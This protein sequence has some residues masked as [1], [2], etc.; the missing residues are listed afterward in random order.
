MKVHLLRKLGCGVLLI[1]LLSVEAWGI[2]PD[3][4]RSFEDRSE[5]EYL[6]LPAVA[7][8]PGV[9]V[10]AGIL[11]SFSNIESTGVD[12][13]VSIAESI[14][15]TD[16]HLRVA[17]LREIPLLIPGLTFDYLFGDIFFGNFQ[18]Y[19]PGRDSPNLTIPVTGD[20]FF[21][22][23]APSLRVWERRINL[24]YALSFSQ[25]FTTDENGNEEKFA[26]H[27]LGLEAE[28][29]FT[30][31]V[32]DPSE[33]IRL[34]YTQ[35]LEAPNSSLF[36]SDSGVEDDDDPT[37][38]SEYRLSVYFPLYEDFTLVWFYQYFQTIG[39]ETVGNGGGNTGSLLLRGYP[40][41]RWRDIYGNATALEGRY[42]IRTNT[43]IDII[44]IKGVI[45][46]W[47]LAAFYEVGQVSPEADNRL[48][49]DLHVSTGAGVRMLLEAIVLR[50]DLATSDEG[51]QTY[52][53]IDQAF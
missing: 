48:Y 31:D 5:N 41:N 12:A 52:L 13:A 19:L 15:D 45:E 38:T 16:I 2:V 20:I 22:Q 7:S 4:R 32:I 14:D 26:A 21:Q 27:N 35:D 39:L 40:Q 37:T 24:T 36:G 11:S 43:P 46:G 10:F 28:L 47:Q 29:D 53:T 6:I 18:T 23:L 3:R 1:W 25:G 17:A 42:T 51:P 50:F 30:D 44:L 34:I 8:I 9:G 49:E 33:G